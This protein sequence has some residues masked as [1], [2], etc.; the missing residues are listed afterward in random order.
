MKN[1]RW[2]ELVDTVKTAWTAKYSVGA[3]I[4]SLI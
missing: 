3:S 4:S 2:A 1:R